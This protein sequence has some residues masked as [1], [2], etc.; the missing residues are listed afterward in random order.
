LLESRRA[1]ATLVDGTAAAGDQ[2]A[3]EATKVGS[4]SVN[5]ARVTRKAGAKNY[6]IVLGTPGDFKPIER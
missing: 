2:F 4:L 1:S 6:N 5:G 3:F